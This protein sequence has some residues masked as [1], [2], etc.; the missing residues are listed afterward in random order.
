[1]LLSIYGAEHVIAESTYFQGC[2]LL[3]W[4]SMN[5]QA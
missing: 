2:I 3:I 5:K 1:M 4:M